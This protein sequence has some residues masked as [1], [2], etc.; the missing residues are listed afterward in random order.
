M[1]ELMVLLE[2]ET[3][4]LASFVT[5]LKREQ[6]ILKLAEVK[7]LPEINEQKLKLIEQLNDIEIARGKALDLVGAQ[8]TPAATTERLSSRAVDQTT[9]SRWKDVLELARQAKQLH[10]LNGRLIQM[11]LQHTNELLAA[12]TQQSEN[13]TL[14]GSSG[15]ACLATGSRIVDSA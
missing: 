12:L 10:E 3:K 1:S 6:D 4:L 7:L 8:N 9:A 5:L 15:Q 14:Y 2:Q 13:H 11:H